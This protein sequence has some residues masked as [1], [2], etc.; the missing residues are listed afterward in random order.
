MIP[1]Q[2]DL[3]CT[4]A[5]F[6]LKNHLKMKS[7]NKL[8]EKV[9]SYSRIEYFKC[10]PVQNLWK[11]TPRCQTCDQEFS[12]KNSR[13]TSPFSLKDTNF[14]RKIFKIAS[15]SAKMWTFNV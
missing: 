2:F 10:L 13:A 5:R 3:W 1:F 4:C 12:G 11:S 8:A 14:R 15:I 7:A 9:P 6:A